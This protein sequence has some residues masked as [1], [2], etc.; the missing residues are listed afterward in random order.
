[1]TENGII[2]TDE[3]DIWQ[4]PNNLLLTPEQLRQLYQQSKEKEVKGE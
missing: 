4:T 2:I 3:G 1:M